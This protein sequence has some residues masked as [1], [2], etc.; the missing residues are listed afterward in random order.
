M[1]CSPESEM[2]S[3]KGAE[4]LW[5]TSILAK[6]LS[7]LQSRHSTDCDPAKTQILT[8]VSVDQ[9]LSPPPVCVPASLRLGSG[10]RR[11]RPERTVRISFLLMCPESEKDELALNFI[12]KETRQTKGT[13]LFN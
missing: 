10:W 11:S 5:K 1:G 8:S 13:R 9:G 4:V 12:H 6:L 2:A 3:E 7:V